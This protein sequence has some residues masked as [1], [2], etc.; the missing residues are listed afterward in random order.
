MCAPGGDGDVRGEAD[1][2]GPQRPAVLSNA[3]WSAA[4][5]PRDMPM[6]TMRLGSTHGCAA[7]QRQP[8]TASASAS[9]W[10]CQT[11]DWSS[12]VRRTPRGTKLSTTSE[13]MPSRAK[14]RA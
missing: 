9:D 13:A 3:A 1:V 8:A 5:P 2:R 4:V 7:S 10:I 12:P 14:A 6:T 11:R